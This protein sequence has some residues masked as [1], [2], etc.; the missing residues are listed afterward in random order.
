M[1]ERRGVDTSCR[2]G[3]RAGWGEG[4]RWIW[5]DKLRSRETGGGHGEPHERLYTFEKKKLKNGPKK[6]LKNACRATDITIAVP[7]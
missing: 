4:G 3:R 2:E 1:D 5:G 6:K 7:C